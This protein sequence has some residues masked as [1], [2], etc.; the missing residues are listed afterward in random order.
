MTFLFGPGTLSGVRGFNDRSTVPLASGF[1]A[2]Y[3][4]V[5]DSDLSQYMLPFRVDA[6]QTNAMCMGAPEMYYP[7][8]EA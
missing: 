1:N 4:P 6:N 7:T 5:D 8:G 2:F 3:Q